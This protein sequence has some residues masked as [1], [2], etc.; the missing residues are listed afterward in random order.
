MKDL[1]LEWFSL[2]LFLVISYSNVLTS[3]NKFPYLGGPN[4]NSTWLDGM[5]NCQG[6]CDLEKSY[7]ILK[8]FEL[9]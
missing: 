2:R 3:S 4:Y 9:E 6:E 7:V 1:I 5:T 8:D